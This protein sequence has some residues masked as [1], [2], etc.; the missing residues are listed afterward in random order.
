M[1]AAASDLLG[2]VPGS[3]AEMARKMLG[4]EVVQGAPQGGPSAV[5]L[6]WHQGRDRDPAH[7]FLRKALLQAARKVVKG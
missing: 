3:M 2:V 5:R 4:L 6:L 1:V 7:R